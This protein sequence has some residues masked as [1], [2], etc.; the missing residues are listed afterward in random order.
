[1]FKEKAMR[2]SFAS[3]EPF[4]SGEIMDLHY[5]RHYLGY[6]NNLNKALEKYPEFFNLSVNDILQKINSVPDDIK[7]AIRNN[8]GGVSN[9]EIFW[10]ILD[11]K[12][13]TIHDGQLK[14]DIISTFSS[15][16]NFREWFE[17]VVASSFGA[18]WVWLVLSKDK[19]LKIIFC[20]NQDSPYMSGDLPIFGIDIWEHAYYLQYK[21]GKMAYFKEVWKILDWKVIENR[22]LSF[23]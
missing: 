7:T 9:H 13:T 3:Y 2:A 17:K 1:M 19:K 4:I 14:R 18:G 10:D 11:T 16:D 20:Q 23:I 22:Y 6:L 15:W 8:G 12:E 21:N 5:T